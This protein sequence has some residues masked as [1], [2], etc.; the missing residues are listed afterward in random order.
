[1]RLRQE[2]AEADDA[3]DADPR[4][5]PPEAHKDGWRHNHSEPDGRGKSHKHLFFPPGRLGAPVPRGGI[6]TGEAHLLLSY[7]FPQ[8]P[9]PG[10]P[11]GTGK[12]VEWLAEQS[13]WSEAA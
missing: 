8:V 3:Q 6:S 1:M 11:P 9:A 5:I 7:M 10:T 13:P 2:Y 12:I 4:M